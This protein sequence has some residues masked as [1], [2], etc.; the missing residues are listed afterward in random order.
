MKIEHLCH[1]NFTW[2]ELQQALADSIECEANDVVAGT[3]KNLQLLQL[4]E[5]ARGQHSW[6]ECTENGVVLA[7]DGVAYTEEI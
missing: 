7:I 3:P 4:A 1:I 5:K 6:V 2:K